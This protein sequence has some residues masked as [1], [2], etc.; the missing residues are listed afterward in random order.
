MYRR[1]PGSRSTFCCGFFVHP[2]SF[3]PSVPST[4]IPYSHNRGAYYRPL[5]YYY[6]Y[7]YIYNSYIIINDVLICSSFLVIPASF[8]QNEHFSFI[9]PAY[10]DTYE[11]LV[12][13]I[14]GVHSHIMPSPLKQPNFYFQVDWRVSKLAYTLVI[15]PKFIG[16]IIFL[17]RA[18]N[19]STNLFCGSSF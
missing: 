2:E 16:S 3:I 18:K 17:N 11:H 6:Y 8:F 7:N 4:G 5:Y 12:C 15:L 9:S 1:Y 19:S 14:E 10:C 13:W